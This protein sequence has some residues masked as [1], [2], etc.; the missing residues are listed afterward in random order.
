MTKNE[1]IENKKTENRKTKEGK[2]ESQVESVKVKRSV[3]G[4]WQERE[5]KEGMLRLCTQM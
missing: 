5:R 1:G 4:E 3:E 2:R